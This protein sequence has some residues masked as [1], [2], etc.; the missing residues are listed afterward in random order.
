MIKPTKNKIDQKWVPEKPIYNKVKTPS[1]L[2]KF[3]VL[4]RFF[5]VI[6]VFPCK[7]ED[8]FTTTVINP[9]IFLAK[10]LLITSMLLGCYITSLWYMLE[11]S[12]MGF[13]L[14]SL[15]TYMMNFIS[16][17]ITKVC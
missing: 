13:N 4:L 3:N 2:A 6:G 7:F 5:S 1:V 15:Q 10:W 16:S 8:D 12:D 9:W 17:T 14:K 11:Q